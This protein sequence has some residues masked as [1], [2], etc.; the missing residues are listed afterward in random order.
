MRKHGKFDLLPV[1]TQMNV[2][3]YRREVLPINQ[4]WNQKGGRYEN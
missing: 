4:K 1:Q 2:L 3:V